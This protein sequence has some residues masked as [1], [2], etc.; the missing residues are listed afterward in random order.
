MTFL[1]LLISTS[2]TRI[3]GLSRREKVPF[4][5]EPPTLLCRRLVEPLRRCLF[6]GSTVWLN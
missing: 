6:K 1:L 5:V 4:I 3:F 2:F